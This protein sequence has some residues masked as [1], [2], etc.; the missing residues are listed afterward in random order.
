MNS[1]IRYGKRLDL[2]RTKQCKKEV[3]LKILIG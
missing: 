1:M 3:N 2:K